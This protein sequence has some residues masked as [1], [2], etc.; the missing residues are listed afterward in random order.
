MSKMQERYLNIEFSYKLIIKFY[1]MHYDLSSAFS[2]SSLSFLRESR[3]VLE[4][5]DN[6]I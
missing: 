2:F 6:Y 3:V 4:V 5:T 1:A